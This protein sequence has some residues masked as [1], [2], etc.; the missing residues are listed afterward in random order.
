MFDIS[1]YLPENILTNETLKSEFPDWDYLK[2]QDKIGIKQRHIVGISETAL[3]LAYRA[4]EKLLID[5]KRELV[6]FIILCTQSPDFILPTSA[7]ILQDRLGLQTSIGALDFNL[8]CSGYVYGLSL[9]KGLITAG[10]SESLLLVTAET[11]T[12]HINRK[13]VANRALFGDGASA[14]LINKH[15]LSGIGQFTLGT[16]GRG[17][18]NLIVQNGG[19]RNAYDVNPQEIEYGNSNWYTNNNLYMNGPEIFNFTIENVPPLVKNNLKANNLTI[20]EIDYFIFHQANQFMLEYLRRKLEIPTEKFCIDLAETGNT[21]SCT[22]PIALKNAYDN[23]KI[24]SGN[25]VMLV[26]FGVGYS[27]GAVTIKI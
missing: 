14:T 25:K 27:W 13:D 3:D 19:Q 20:K 9:A 15:D 7:C 22:I 21:V 16:D 26:G 4:S 10:I 8:G 17:K 18:N 1:L 2:I 12:K 24:R 6:D 5:K 11:Y 23:R